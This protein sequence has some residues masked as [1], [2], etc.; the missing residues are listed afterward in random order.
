MWQAWKDEE[1]RR[2]RVEKEYERLM[3]MFKKALKDRD[4]LEEE[5]KILKATCNGMNLG[6]PEQCR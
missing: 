1:Q 2:M 4:E 3:S 5:V 6:N